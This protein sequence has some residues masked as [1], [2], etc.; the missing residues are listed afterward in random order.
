LLVNLSSLTRGCDLAGE[1]K[2]LVQGGVGDG[3]LAGLLLRGLGEIEE[4][5]Q[6]VPVGL[7]QHVSEVGGRSLL[8]YHLYKQ[9]RA[10]KN[11]FSDRKITIVSIDK[12][13]YFSGMG[14]ASY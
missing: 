14:F 1:L 10:F 12:L 9:I 7:G 8:L 3:H 2:L 13:R 6:R 4:V 5:A 11:H